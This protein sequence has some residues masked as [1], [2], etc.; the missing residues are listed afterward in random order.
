MNL[1]KRLKTLW[2]L[3]SVNTDTVLPNVYKG[4]YETYSLDNKPRMAQI[5]KK[6][7]P[8]EEFLK[9]NKNES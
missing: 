7:T 5:I 2:A 6:N 3:S 4:K 1:I 8:T 9:K